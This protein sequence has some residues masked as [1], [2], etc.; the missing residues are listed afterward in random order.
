M[1]PGVAGKWSQMCLSLFILHSQY[2]S[3]TTGGTLLQ[4]FVYA[5]TSALKGLLIFS[6]FPGISWGL[7]KWSCFQLLPFQEE[8]SFCFPDSQFT[9]KFT[10]GTQFF[11]RLRTSCNMIKLKA[12]DFLLQNCN[13]DVLRPHLNSTVIAFTTH[14]LP[15][16]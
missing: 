5:S 13:L 15:S 1:A 8:S 3:Y 4:L 11:H 7:N 16:S 12:K 6:N 14:I 10:L 2:L 9:N